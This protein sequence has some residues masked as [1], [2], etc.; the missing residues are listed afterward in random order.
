MANSGGLYHDGN[1]SV[2]RPQRLSSGIGAMVP[3]R[4]ACHVEVRLV[5]ENFPYYA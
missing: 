1:S 2:E 5:V 4:L 3:T